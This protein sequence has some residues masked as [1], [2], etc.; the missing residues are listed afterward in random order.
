M[1]LRIVTVAT[2]SARYFDSLIDS[3]KKNNVSI[4]ILGEGEKWKGFT[5]RLN[6][7]IDFLKACDSDDIVIFVDGYDVILLPTIKNIIPKFVEIKQRRD[8]KILIGVD[9]EPES[10]LHKYAYNKVFATNKYGEKNLNAGAYMGF[11]KE[12][13]EMFHQICEND[14]CENSKDDQILI[15]QNYSK[16]EDL[17]YIDENHEIFMNI[18]GDVLNRNKVSL[19]KNN[20]EL[21]TVTDREKHIFDSK[22]NKQP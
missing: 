10:F 4:T 22:N 8:F 7:M 1:Q 13:L 11:A 14:N 6:L 12:L 16:N 9:T 18:F 17:F 21:I 5:W 20:F 19:T 15:R 3:A 2:H